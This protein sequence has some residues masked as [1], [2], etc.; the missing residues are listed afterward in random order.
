MPSNQEIGV[1]ELTSKYR[2]GLTSRGAPLYLFKPYNPESPDLIVGS[3]ERDLSRNQIA[4]VEVAEEAKHLDRGSLIRLVGPVGDPKSEIDSLLLHY[5]GSTKHKTET[6]EVDASDDENRVVI[7]ADSGWVTF[8]IDPPGCRD[9]D[10][11]IA[12]HHETRTWAITIADAA[13][14]VPVGSLTD[15]VAKAIGAT[16]YDLEG[17]AILSMLPTAISEYSASLLP[18][19][20]RRGIS[21]FLKPNGTTI[22]QRSWI[23][24]KHSFT[25][26]SFT[27]SDVAYKL[28][29]SKDP[30]EWIE[31]LMI[32][33]NREA[34]TL[35]KNAGAGLLR[36]QPETEETPVWARID[37]TLKFLAAEAAS[38]EAVTPDTAQTHATLGLYC[39][40]SSP[41]RRYADLVNQ[42]ALKAIFRGDPP[43]VSDV[44]DHLNR[45]SKANKRWSRDLTFLTH[46][47]PGRVHQIDVVWLSEAKVWVPSWKRI[48]RLRHEESRHVGTIGPIQ[49]FCDPTKR[50]WR[51]RVLTNS[52]SSW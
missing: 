26:E 25:Y 48:I 28:H 2:Y 1:L 47:T 24:V 17:R 23:T 21:L 45:R 42:R 5:A 13:A 10:D 43:L 33:Y 31:E 20:P 36:V 18:G 49:I 11:A 37:P 40:A 27:R 52:V 44:A 41:L 29:I 46:V 9:V 16:F 32:R 35:L 12:Y 39:H 22:F 34:A 6:L 51:E 3:T 8:H 30:H 4:I 38:Y 14:A 15:T 50:N 19:E 7:N